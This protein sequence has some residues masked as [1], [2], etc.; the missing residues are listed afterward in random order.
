MINQLLEEIKDMITSMANKN[1]IIKDLTEENETLKIELQEANS[2][3]ANLNSK[4]DELISENEK[5]QKELEDYKAQENLDLEQ[6]EVAI[7]ELKSLI[8][9]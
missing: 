8:N 4:V 1:K 6:L 7:N 3:I 5:A 9:E 2:K